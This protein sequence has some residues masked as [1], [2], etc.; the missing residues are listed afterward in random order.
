MLGAFNYSTCMQIY[1]SLYFS[2]VLY[3]YCICIS[4]YVVCIISLYTE[5]SVFI[6]CFI[7]TPCNYVVQFVFVSCSINAPK[8]LRLYIVFF[9]FKCIYNTCLWKWSFW[10]QQVFEMNYFYLLRERSYRIISFITSFSYLRNYP[11][12]KRSRVFMPRQHYSKKKKTTN[13]FQTPSV[14]L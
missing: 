1:L 4:L 10:S 14:Q 8:H 11:S 3:T 6:N 9:F 7:F 2:H 5:C 12:H 13:N